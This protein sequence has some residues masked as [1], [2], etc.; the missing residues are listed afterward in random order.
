M[1]AKLRRELQHQGWNTGL[2]SSQIIP[3]IIGSPNEAVRLSERLRER[4]YWVPAIR[5]PSVPEGESLLRLSL[6]A[7]HTAEMVEGLLKALEEIGR[8]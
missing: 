7:G 4:G 3:L 6:T 8:G 5:P 1:A 2:S